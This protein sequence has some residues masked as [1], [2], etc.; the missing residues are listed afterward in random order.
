MAGEARG[1]EAAGLAL[2][3]HRSAQGGRGSGYDVL[4][5]FHGGAGLFHGGREPSWQPCR[6]AWE[7]AFFLFPGP[8]PV[9]TPDAIDRYTRW[10]Q[11]DP[12]S[13]RD[14]LRASNAG[15]QRLL[16]AVTPAEA[17][18]AMTACRGLGIRVGEA[19]GVDAWISAPPGSDPSWCKAAGAGNEL[20]ILAVPRGSK[21]P[22]APGL[23]PVVPSPEG[24]TWDP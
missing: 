8:A 23:E 22:A 13:A 6:L 11:R 20:G 21:P 16:A 3:A 19:I 12:Q 18:D 2:R 5:S 17:A 15:I 7:P 9:S 24:V 10:K 1:A 14:F 4:C